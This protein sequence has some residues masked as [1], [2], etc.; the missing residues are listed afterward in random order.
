MFLDVQTMEP[1]NVKMVR[2]KP[3]TDINGIFRYLIVKEK[4]E[5]VKK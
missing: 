3:G 5:S 1:F 4:L 2:L